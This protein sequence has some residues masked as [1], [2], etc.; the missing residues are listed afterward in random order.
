[1]SAAN[2][3]KVD[4]PLPMLLENGQQFP[5]VVPVD[6]QGSS[7]QLA[8]GER[9]IGDRFRFS[10][11]RSGL[12]QVNAPKLGDYQRA[13]D[14]LNLLPGIQAMLTGDDSHL[15]ED[16]L[17][18]GKPRSQWLDFI[19]YA[20]SEK[21]MGLRRAQLLELSQ[22]LGIEVEDVPENTKQVLAEGLKTLQVS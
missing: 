14:P 5:V 10:I 15:L 12:R 22:F 2:T 4:R 6:R 16:P 17:Y 21:L 8:P 13:R 11:T 18:E 1:M 19:Q 7:Q 20:D 9:I 3:K